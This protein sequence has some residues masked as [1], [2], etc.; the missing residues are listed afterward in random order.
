MGEGKRG[1][2]GPSAADAVA[3]TRAAQTSV[4][5][6]DNLRGGCLPPPVRCERG[7]TLWVGLIDNRQQLTKLP[8]K[9][10][11]IYFSSMVITRSTGGFSTTRSE[12]RRVGKEGRSRWSPYH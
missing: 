8:H 5:Q 11:S 7:G 3:S 10:P 2:P 1:A 6:V 12:E 9:V 4:G